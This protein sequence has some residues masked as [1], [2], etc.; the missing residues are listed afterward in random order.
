V[1][2]TGGPGLPGDVDQGWWPLPGWPV[3]VELDGRPMRL[4]RPDTGQTLAALARA[5]TGA[6]VPGLLRG[7]DVRWLDV[8]LSDPDDPL[9]LWE[10]MALG[11]SV[12]AHVARMPWWAAVQLAATAREVWPTLLGRAALGGSDLV[13]LGVD[14]VLSACWALLREGAQ[15]EDEL[16]GLH[17]QVFDARPADIEFAELVSPGSV[18]V[19]EA[20]W[21]GEV[22]VDFSGFLGDA[23]GVFT[24]PTPVLS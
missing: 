21:A 11:R 15:T 7:D 17:R 2:I 9:D 16:S 4:L 12:G 22:A 24:L 18:D 8:L 23:G 13:A 19:L 6:F 1:P 5:N 20:Q 3:V 10:V 14:G